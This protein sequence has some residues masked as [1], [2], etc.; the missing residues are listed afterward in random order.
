MIQTPTRRFD[1][2]GTW[3]A[4]AAVQ[5]SESDIQPCIPL[6]TKG[7]EDRSFSFFCPDANANLRAADRVSGG[8]LGRNNW[9]HRI[10]HDLRD[11]GSE[12]LS[13]RWLAKERQGTN[14]DG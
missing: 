5:L 4:G 14:N 6:Q 13:V 8:E 7:I 10:Q 12:G 11:S 2:S 1:P 3:R 9:F